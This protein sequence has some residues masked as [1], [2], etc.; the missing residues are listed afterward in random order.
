MRFKLKKHFCLKDF[1][2]CKLPQIQVPTETPVGSAKRDPSV[3]QEDNS[4]WFP[5][6]T[7]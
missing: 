1:F 7:A 3:A 6:V 4:L 5:T 2:F